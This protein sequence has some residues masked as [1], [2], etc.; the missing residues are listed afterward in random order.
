VGVAC[1]ILSNPK[2]QG[3][4]PFDVASELLIGADKNRISDP[5]GRFQQRTV[6]A[7]AQVA[8]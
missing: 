1:T 8:V 4:T 6:N 2:V 3:K 5:N 7:V